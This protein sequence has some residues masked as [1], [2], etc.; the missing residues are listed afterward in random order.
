[1]RK[2]F[3]VILVSSGLFAHTP[4]LTCMD[5]GDGTVTCEGGFSDGSSAGGVNFIV[6]QGEKILIETKLNSTSEINFKKPSG[7][8]VA[9]FDAGNEHRVYLKSSE[10]FE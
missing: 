1:M 8:Y 7:D 10:I 5:E 3:L 4:L 6:K 2:V 9:I